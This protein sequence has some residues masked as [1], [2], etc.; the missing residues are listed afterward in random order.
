MSSDPAALLAKA[1]RLREQ[2]E[3]EIQRQAPPPR[4]QPRQPV[5]EEPAESRF[6]P[7]NRVFCVPYGE[8]IVQKARVRDGHELLLVQF[9][10]LGE[11][12]IDPMVNAVRLITTASAEEFEESDE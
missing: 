7:G 11:L 4:P 1:R 5:D 10:E 2:R 12:R 6:S 3:A 8:G 9:P